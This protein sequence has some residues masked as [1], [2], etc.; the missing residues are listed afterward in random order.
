MDATNLERS[1]G[2]GAMLTGRRRVGNPHLW[3]C[4]VIV[5]KTT[6]CG[7]RAKYWHF[8]YSALAL[9]AVNRLI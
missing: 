2:G 6:L 8:D 5:G 7:F 4:Q 9:L 1:K 3:C